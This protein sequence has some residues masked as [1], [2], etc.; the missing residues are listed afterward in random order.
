MI[1]PNKKLVNF[2]SIFY[3][4]YWGYKKQIIALTL[5]GFLSSLLEGIGINAAIPM[6]S[7]ISGTSDKADD[8]ISKIIKKFFDFLQINFSLKYLFIFICGL[9]MLRVLILLLS[10]YIKI[11][12]TAVYEEKTRGELFKLTAEANWQYLIK[13]KLGY[14]DTILVTNVQ[15]GS[16]L[17]QTISSS[18]MIVASLFI[19]LLVAINIS[20]QITLITL[21]L[22]G[23]MFFVFKPFLYK[24][25]SLSRENEKINRFTAHHI[26]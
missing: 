7:F 18:L 17:L 21:V 3:R 24:T 13:Q 5:L 1:L 25:R 20:P 23:L 15:N 4:A 11:K 2:F 14:L 8:P 9:L 19:F 26:N 22:G 6:F 16:S 12:I 10:N